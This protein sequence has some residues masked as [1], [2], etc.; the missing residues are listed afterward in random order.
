MLQILRK[1]GRNLSS[2]QISGQAEGHDRSYSLLWIMT[3]ATEKQ[4]KFSP[5]AAYF[6]QNWLWGKGRVYIEK[7]QCQIAVRTEQGLELWF[8]DFGIMRTS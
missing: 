8:Y 4:G 6:C 3:T 2:T 7:V 5:F 1:T